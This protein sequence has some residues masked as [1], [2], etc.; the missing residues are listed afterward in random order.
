MRRTPFALAALF[1]LIGLSALAAEPAWYTNNGVAAASARFAAAAQ[2]SAPRYDQA[3]KDL[4]AASA[5][6]Q[7]L[8]LGA[9]LGAGAAEA[10]FGPWARD[11]R[12]R[13]N[14]LFLALE[15]DVEKA[16]E[17]YSAAFEAAVARALPPVAKGRTVTE[18]RPR[19]GSM[20][21]P[22]K[23]NCPGEDLSK[24][25][26]AQVDKDPVLEAAV[27]ELSAQLFPDVRPKPRTFAPIPLTGGT[28]IVSL[29]RLGK[30]FAKEAVARHQAALLA[31]IEPLE[32]RIADGDAAALEAAKKARQDYEAAMAQTGAALIEATKGLAERAEKTGGITQIGLCANPA[33]LGGCGGEDIS[34][35]IIALGKEDKKFQKAVGAL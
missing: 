33:A 8:E 26:A 23:P 35:M 25:I 28:N 1:A 22:G 9:L 4:E 14:A 15:R 24:A 18:C 31:A 27:K 7:E 11:T 12:K 13:T 30:V 3:Q 20:M 29:P 10:E 19:G 17:A 2:A 32:T 6:L 34:A 21:M 5:T 16:T